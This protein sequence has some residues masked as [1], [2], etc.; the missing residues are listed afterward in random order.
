MYKNFR[1]PKKTLIIGVDGASPESVEKFIIEGKLPNI[2]ALMEKGVF[3]KALPVLPTHTPVNWTTIG[4]DPG[5][6]PMA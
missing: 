1:I 4:Q 2:K 6:E 5:R 3:A